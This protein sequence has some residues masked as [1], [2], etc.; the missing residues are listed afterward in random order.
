MV[1]QDRG[2]ADRIGQ[3]FVDDLPDM[4]DRACA[5]PGDHGDRDASGDPAGQFDVE[6]ATGS[7]PVD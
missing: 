4:F 1:M 5:A 7:F 3:P 6:S 2:E